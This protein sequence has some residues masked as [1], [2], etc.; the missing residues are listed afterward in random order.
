MN[1]LY[2]PGPIEYIPN[3]IARKHGREEI[4]YDLEGMEDYLARIVW[5]YSLP[6]ASDA[7]LSKASGFSKGDA[8]MLRKAMGKKIFALLEK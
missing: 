3:F 2:R 8:D 5:Y 1:A 6:R 4:T 7:P